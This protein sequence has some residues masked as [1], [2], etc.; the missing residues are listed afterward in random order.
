MN[1]VVNKPIIYQWSG[2]TTETKT[3]PTATGIGVKN[4]GSSSLT[5]TVNGMSFTVASGENFEDDF[6]KFDSVTIT[7]SSTY[8]AFVRG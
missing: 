8:E 4:L 3:V 6:N 2:S 7:A 1:Q 5:L